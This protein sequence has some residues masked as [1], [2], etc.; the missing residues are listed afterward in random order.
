MLPM[1]LFG[2]NMSAEIYNELTEETEKLDM[3]NLDPELVEIFMSDRFSDF[4]KNSG[5]IED[6]INILESDNLD[7]IKNFFINNQEKIISQ[8]NSLKE[9]LNDF[10]DKGIDLNNMDDVDPTA[11]NIISIISLSVLQLETGLDRFQRRLKSSV[12]EHTTKEDIVISEEDVENVEND[13]T[14]Q[15][16]IKDS[17][18]M[19]QN[20]NLMNIPNKGHPSQ[21]QNNGTYYL[22]TNDSFN[23]FAAYKLMNPT[24]DKLNEILRNCGIQGARLFQMTEVATIKK[25][26]QTTITLVK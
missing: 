8:I 18:K 2:G 10:S 4:C 12:S 15:K 21:T 22:V 11:K 23:Q 1:E 7:R 13:N 19:N 5:F 3:D 16:A 6:T 25:Q 9:L 14:M 17:K 26:I 20:I 24:K